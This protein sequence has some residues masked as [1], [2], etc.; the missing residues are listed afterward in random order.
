MN[1]LRQL[2]YRWR[3]RDCYGEPLEGGLRGLSLSE[4]FCSDT[5]EGTCLTCWQVSAMGGYQWINLN[6][7]IAQTSS[8][9]EIC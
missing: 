8:G 7:S 3:E 1:P 6:L 5:A 4:Q 2:D 9:I